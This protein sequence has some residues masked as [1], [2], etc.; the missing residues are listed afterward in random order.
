[1]LEQLRGIVQ[2]VNAA[3]ELQ[4][5]LDIIVSKVRK[6]LDAQVCSVFLYDSDLNAH[7]LMAIMTMAHPFRLARFVI[8]GA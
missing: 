8:P 1:M 3:G 5:A 4:A 6:A 7:V 2:E